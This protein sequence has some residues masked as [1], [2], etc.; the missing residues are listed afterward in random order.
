VHKQEERSKMIKPM[1]ANLL[2]KKIDSVD[3][4][5]KSGLVISAALVDSDLTQ[6]TVILV[7]DGEQ[8]YLG[9]TIK[10]DYISVGDVIYYAERN[11]T[12][13]EDFETSE[14]YYLVNAKNVMAKR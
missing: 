3:R 4:T 8:N 12:E 6:A 11:G 9:D 2:V 7:G 10:V 5:T 1:G 14:K 13:I